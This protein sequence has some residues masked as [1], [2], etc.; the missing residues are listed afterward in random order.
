LL[1]DTDTKVAI[2]KS[3]TALKQN[4]PTTQ[5][6]IKIP[7]AVAT[8]ADLTGEWNIEYATVIGKISSGGMPFIERVRIS[9]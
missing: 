1:D 6:S 5:A 9:A 3:I 4:E 2:T 7:Q 8:I